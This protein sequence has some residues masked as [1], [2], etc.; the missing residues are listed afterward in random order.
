MCTRVLSEAARL[1]VPLRLLVLS[2]GEDEGE[3]LPADD[4]TDLAVFSLANYPQWQASSADECGQMVH[5]LSTPNFSDSPAVVS[6]QLRVS[7]LSYVTGAPLS[8]QA[9]SLEPITLCGDTNNP[10]WIFIASHA[11]ADAGFALAANSYASEVH[12]C[13]VNVRRV[14]PFPVEELRAVISPRATVIVH[15]RTGPA[16]NGPSISSHVVAALHSLAPSQPLSIAV[17]R[18]AG[19]YGWWLERLATLTEQAVDVSVEHQVW[20][21]AE[22]RCKMLTV[23]RVLSVLSRSNVRATAEAVAA[24]R[25]VIRWQGKSTNKMGAGSL[26]VLNVPGLSVGLLVALAPPNAVCETLPSNQGDPTSAAARI[27]HWIANTLPSEKAATIEDT[28]KNHGD[29]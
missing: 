13:A 2:H 17:A 6:I 11:A 3:T 21:V 27:L 19:S 22:P 14:W 24:E 26:L 5:A 4:M 18:G 25:A 7:A 1:H 9:S 16:E 20:I 10:R 15:D 23:E 8:S 28:R 12:V 29:F